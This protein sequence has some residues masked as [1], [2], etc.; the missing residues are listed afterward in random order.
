[1]GKT[2]GLQYGFVS[3]WLY[4]FVPNLDLLGLFSLFA[5]LG[6]S[7]AHASQ[8]LIS[9]RAWPHL[10]WRPCGGF[11]KIQF[12]ST[13]ASQAGACAAQHLKRCPQRNQ[14]HDPEQGFPY[15]GESSLSNSEPV[16]ERVSEPLQA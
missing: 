9:Q 12:Y 11:T 5:V 2:P 14:I 10:K 13:S 16:R 15:R 8:A 6:I 1:M 3:T 7:L 4:I